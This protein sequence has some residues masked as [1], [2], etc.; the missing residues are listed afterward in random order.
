MDFDLVIVGLGPVGAVAANLAGMWGLKTLAVDKLPDV[1]DKPRAFGLD[2]E[3]MRV[4]QN[5]GIASDIEHCVM[6]YR[7]SEYQTTGGAVLKRIAPAAPP[8]LLGW[9]PNYV[10]SQPA[11][12]R[13]LR[14]RMK[15]HAGMNVQLETEVLGVEPADGGMRVTLRD[16][17]GGEREVTASYVLACDG[18]TSPI[19]TRLGLEMEDMQ[20]DEPWLVVDVLVKDEHHPRLPQTNVQF[21]EV[22]RPSSFIVGPGTHRRWEFMINPD[23]TPAEIAQPDNIR[24]LL[25]RWLEPHEYEIWRA[26]TYRFHALVLKS[27]RRGNLF[28]L[29]DAAHMT[30]PFM[31]Q[32]MCQGIRDAAN[33][34]WKLAL[35]NKGVRSDALLDSYQEER[36]PHVRQTTQVA[37]ELGKIIC[38]R[39]AR[40]AAQ[41]DARLQEEF[42]RVGTVVRQSLI[43]GLASGLIAD[44]AR[45]R[46]AGSL[47]PQP[48]VVDMHGREGRLDDFTG[49]GFCIVFAAHIDPAEMEHELAGWEQGVGVP[50]ARVRLAADAAQG[51]EAAHD[52]RDR[53]GSLCDWMEQHGCSIV[54][55]RPDHYVYGSARSAQE[56]AELVR[57]LRQVLLQPEY[58]L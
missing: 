24:R 21:C 15:Q 51:R 2:H 45:D 40:T 54:L 55:V 4:F 9:A 13:A 18:G 12:E 14:E 22:G 56:G 50:L 42:A 31:A 19:R 20:F 44:S 37:K 23:E 38:E 10:F 17:A 58:A 32:G 52:Y 48:W 34:V 46:T 30:P 39:D 41:R 25:Q 16:G 49:Q 6:P 3:V 26:A 5:I 11:V 35:A 28:F 57:Q 47:F 27:W 43:P 8:H 1:Y 36:I 53:D 29:G 33:L 7:T